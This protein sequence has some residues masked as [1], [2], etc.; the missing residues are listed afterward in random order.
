MKNEELPPL[1]EGDLKISEE[2]FPTDFVIK[3]LDVPNFLSDLASGQFV[4]KIELVKPDGE[5]ADSIKKIGPKYKK[6]LQDLLRIYNNGLKKSVEYSIWVV[7]HPIDTRQLNS[8]QGVDGERGYELGRE[9]EIFL[10]PLSSSNDSLR[11]FY[12]YKD[13]REEHECIFGKKLVDR[14]KQR[15]NYVAS[16]LEK[17]LEHN[18]YNSENNRIID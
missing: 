8:Y 7:L 14:L 4:F 16:L 1:T 18:K 10:D 6:N 13:P 11:L 17:Y 3:K 2:L 15:C 12:V 9:C 5:K